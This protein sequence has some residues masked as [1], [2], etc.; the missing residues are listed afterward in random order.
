MS[1]VSSVPFP[2][3]VGQN[4]QYPWRREGFW[5]SLLAPDWSVSP[6]TF[7]GPKPEWSGSRR[8][9]TVVWIL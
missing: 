3:D 2:S 6:R 1:R 7:P 5:I 8:V 4:V 9:W